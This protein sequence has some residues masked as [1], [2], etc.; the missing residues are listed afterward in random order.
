VRTPLPE[1][2]AALNAYQPQVVFTYPSVVARLAEEQQ[3]GR[4][5]IRPARFVSTAEVLTPQ[6]RRAARDAFG[7]PVL[8][9]YGSTEAG[10]FGIE[11]DQ[12]AGIHLAEDMVV[13][14]AVDEAD[15]PVPPGTPSAKVLVTTLYHTPVPMIRYEISDVVTL[16]DDP[17][18]CGRP[19]ARVVALD[20]RHEEMLTLQ[21]RGGGQVRLRAV[22]L[23]SALDGVPGL[24][25][26]Q[27]VPRGPRAILVRV[28]AREDADVAAMVAAVRTILD[29]ELDAAG[30]GLDTLD[31]A[32]VDSIERHG[33]GAKHLFVG[34]EA[35]A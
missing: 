28:T 6:V 17:C 18:P 15:R 24:R 31:V 9:A 16:A 10:L 14:E 2:V 32:V 34:T 3:A 25:Q 1:T 26:F 11:C 23:R 7:A 4:L 30:V 33:T 29:R 21:A 35:G 12:A 5:A 19:Y 13:M 27:I 20:G 8:N 22:R